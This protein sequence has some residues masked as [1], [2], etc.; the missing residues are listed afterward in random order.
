LF[1]GGTELTSGVTAADYSGDPV[2]E[3]R[4]ADGAVLKSYT[5]NIT[6]ASN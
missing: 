5:V 6:E 2:L 4:A 1:L 3:V